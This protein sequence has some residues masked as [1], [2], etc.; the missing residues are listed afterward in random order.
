MKTEQYLCDLCENPIKN[1]NPN[2]QRMIVTHWGDNQIWPI[3]NNGK[4]IDVCL[5][6]C[7][8]LDKAYIIGIIS[9]DKKR[10]YEYHGYKK[11]PG[12]LY[13]IE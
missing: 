9:I 10:L 2:G 8:L 12:G 4:T 11:L 1:Y 6:C 3:D 7:L 5:D 13:K